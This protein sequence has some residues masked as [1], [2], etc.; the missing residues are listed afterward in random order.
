MQF[1]SP[2]IG[3]VSKLVQN[4]R[5]GKKINLNLYSRDEIEIIRHASSD[6]IIH[7]WSYLGDT[8]FNR[9]GYRQ[10]TDTLEKQLNLYKQ[11]NNNAD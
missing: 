4:H 8:R 11:E 10:A 1:Y 9:H 2:G 3:L 5:A 6:Y 7:I